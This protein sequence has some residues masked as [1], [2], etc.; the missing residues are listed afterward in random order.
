MRKFHLTPGMIAGAYEYMRASTRLFRSLPHCDE[1]GFK[2]LTTPRVHGHCR[3]GINGGQSEIAISVSKTGTT[4]SLLE[5]LAHEML[6]LL[7]HIRKTE[8][9]NTE[10]NAEFRRLGLKIS[11]YHGFDPKRF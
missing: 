2:V 1:I 5:T 9:G 11:A 3:G 10:H 8:T 7:Q 6:H 4:L